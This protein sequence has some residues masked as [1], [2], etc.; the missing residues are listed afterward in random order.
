[1]R[2]D[3]FFEAGGLVMLP[4]VVMTLLLWYTLGYRLAAIRRSAS[5][6]NLRERIRRYQ[7]QQWHKPGGIIDE[8]IAQGL[9]IAKQVDG[10]PRPFLDEAFWPYLRRMNRHSALV[11]VIVYSAPLLGLLGTVSGMIETF[12]SLQSMT[13]FSQ[14]GGIA[15][16]ISQALITTQFG[17]A[18]AIPGLLMNGFLEKRA[19]IISME[20]DQLKD[21]ITSQYRAR[22]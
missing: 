9:A 16:G 14:S 4:L 10:D 22:H 8:A 7:S 11:R 1:M 18:V 3:F 19:R 21:I 15:G 5:R 17:L 2:W 20:L 13:L 6:C 12:D